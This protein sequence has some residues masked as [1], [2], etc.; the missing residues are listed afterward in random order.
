MLFLT[1][2][3]NVNFVLIMFR[4]ERQRCFMCNKDLNDVKDLGNLED[5]LIEIYK[6]F[7]RDS[8]EE[9]DLNFSIDNSAFSEVVVDQITKVI[10]H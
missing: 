10:M 7:E 8:E 1:E 4:K 6:S 2:L 9:F 5:W 3:L